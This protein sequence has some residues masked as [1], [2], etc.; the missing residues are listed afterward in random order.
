MTREAPL[1]APGCADVGAEVARLRQV[2][3]L[4]EELA[5]RSRHSDAALNDAAELSARY[6]AALPIDQKRFDALAS[7]TARWAAAGVEA[8]V[9]LDEGGLPV[10]TAAGRLTEALEKALGDLA[11]RL[12][13]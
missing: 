7:E 8:L 4:V 3:A 6:A 1:Y 9:K 11:Q 13:D 10:R 2:L 12:P 5:G